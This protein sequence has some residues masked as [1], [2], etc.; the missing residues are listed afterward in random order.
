MTGSIVLFHHSIV[1][2]GEYSL[3][4]NLINLAIL[5]SRQL[6]KAPTHA[7]MHMSPSLPI[8]LTDISVNRSAQSTDL[9][10]INPNWSKA[11]APRAHSSLVG[12]HLH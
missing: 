4:I 11:P 1:L 6:I 12:M 9:P 7:C 2:I 10:K 5:S 3:A 8:E